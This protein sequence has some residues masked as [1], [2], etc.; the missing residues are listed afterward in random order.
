MIIFIKRL[1]IFLCKLIATSQRAFK[2]LRCTHLNAHTLTHVCMYMLI[3]ILNICIR[4]KY[5]KIDHLCTR[6]NHP[7]NAVR[8][9]GHTH[10]NAHMWTSTKKHPFE[11]L[12]T[13]SHK[14]KLQYRTEH[15]SHAVRTFAHVY[16]HTYIHTCTNNRHGHILYQKF[17]TSLHKKFA[18][19]HN[20]S[21]SYG[22]DST[23][24]RKYFSASSK[25][26]FWS[27]LYCV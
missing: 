15:L 24:R 26:R 14:Q 9:Y 11:N 21:E 18:R 12:F 25:S 27:C 13:S 1:V 17:V 20:A 4:H 5:D 23:A 7:S 10:T 6:I 16:I 8:T 22:E 2:L 19:S 3:Y